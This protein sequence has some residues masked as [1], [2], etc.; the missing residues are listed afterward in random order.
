METLPS[1]LTTQSAALAG[2]E[3]ATVAVVQVSEP[4]AETLMGPELH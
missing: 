1:A 4:V 3:H 2:H